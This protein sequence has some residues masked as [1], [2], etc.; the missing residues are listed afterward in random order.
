MHDQVSF[1]VYNERI[2]E[3]VNERGKEYMHI[4]FL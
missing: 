1:V 2:I 4:E 3:C